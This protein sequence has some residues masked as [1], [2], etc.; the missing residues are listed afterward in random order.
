MYAKESFQNMKAII[1]RSVANLRADLLGAVM[2]TTVH[3]VWKMP[4]S[5]L[6]FGNE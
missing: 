2:E 1:V 3:C 4:S 5:C 6:K